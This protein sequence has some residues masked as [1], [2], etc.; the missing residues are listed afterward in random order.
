MTRFKCCE[1]GI[2]F[3]DCKYWFDTL[4]FEKFEKR[5]I[6]PFCGTECVNKWHVENKVQEW[7]IRKAPYPKGPE[8][9]I[10]QHLHPSMFPWTSS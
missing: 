8:W 2:E 3:D 7:E 6:K 1:C 10:I 4:Y 5:E 9:Q